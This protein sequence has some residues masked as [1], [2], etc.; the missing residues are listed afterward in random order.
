MTRDEREALEKLKKETKEK[1]MARLM[2]SRVPFTEYPQTGTLVIP[3]CNGTIC[4]YLTTNK[5]QHK[6]RIFEGDM[7]Y[8]IQYIAEVNQRT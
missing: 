1:N 7:E 2:N 8:L 5:I 3:S 4:F 6:G